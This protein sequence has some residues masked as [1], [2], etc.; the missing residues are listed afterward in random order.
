MQAD[1]EDFLTES[2]QEERILEG[3]KAV[4]RDLEGQRSLMLHVDCWILSDLTRKMDTSKPQIDADC[5]IQKIMVPAIHNNRTNKL[6]IKKKTIQ[7]F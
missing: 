3:N 5:G 7:N 6:V 4:I 1:E 2:A